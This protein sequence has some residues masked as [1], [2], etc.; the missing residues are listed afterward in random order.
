MAFIP[1]NDLQENTIPEFLRRNAERYPDNDCVV[2]PEFGVRWSW[3]EFDRLTNRIARGMYALGIR[4]GDHVAIWATNVPE[5]LLTMFSTAK[6]GAILITVNTNYKQFE[7]NYLLRQSD[8]K[9]LVMVSG[10]KNND[11][12]SHITGTDA[13]PP[14]PDP[15]KPAATKQQLPCLEEGCA[16]RRRGEKNQRNDRV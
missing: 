6:L 13:Q 8:A 15:R 12:I 5:W 7:L 14:D 11:Y 9:M 4:K 2:A 3:R 10:V 16:D 1:M